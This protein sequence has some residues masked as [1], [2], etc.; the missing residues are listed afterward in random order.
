MISLRLQFKART[1]ITVKIV[2]TRGH[3]WDIKYEFRTKSCMKVNVLDNVLKKLK[4][5]AME[6]SGKPSRETKLKGTLG[7]KHYG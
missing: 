7:N 2:S 5:K 4:E 6:K 3:Q 1:E